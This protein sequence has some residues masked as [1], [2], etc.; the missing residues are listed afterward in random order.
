L[1][2]EAGHHSDMQIDRDFIAS[3]LGFRTYDSETPLIFMI[4]RALKE[5]KQKEIDNYEIS[6]NNN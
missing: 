4:M 2:E 3:E 1:T 6:E 5:I